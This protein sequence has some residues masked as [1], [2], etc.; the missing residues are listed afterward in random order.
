ML[1][2][3]LLKDPINKNSLNSICKKKKQLSFISAFLEIYFKIYF[4]QLTLTSLK[5]L[6]AM[7]P[8]RVSSTGMELLPA[9]VSPETVSAFKLI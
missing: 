3:G 6:T 1:L 2:K 7:R 9:G 8:R 5:S 4:F